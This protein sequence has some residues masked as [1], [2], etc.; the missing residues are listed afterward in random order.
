M[1]TMAPI[2]VAPK[3]LHKRSLERLMNT[4]SKQLREKAILFTHVFR[5]SLVDRHPE[6]YDWSSAN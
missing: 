3:L 4:V 6:F 2:L 1:S 5:F